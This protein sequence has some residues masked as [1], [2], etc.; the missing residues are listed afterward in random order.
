MAG[1]SPVVGL[2]LLFALSGVS[3]MTIPSHGGW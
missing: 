3:G 2:S 1:K